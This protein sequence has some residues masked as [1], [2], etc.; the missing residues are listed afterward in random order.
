MVWRRGCG[1]PGADPERGCR[2]EVD[3]PDEDEEKEEDGGE[4]DRSPGVPVAEGD[5]QDDENA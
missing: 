1:E 3:L 2:P 5:E 4:R